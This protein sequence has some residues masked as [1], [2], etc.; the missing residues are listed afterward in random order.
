M[1]Q[2]ARLPLKR[3]GLFS[4]TLAGIVVLS[5]SLALEQQLRTVVRYNPPLVVALSYVQNTRGGLALDKSEGVSGV[6]AFVVG[7]GCS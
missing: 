7:V 4:A 5:S 3:P 1:D 6:A 2:P